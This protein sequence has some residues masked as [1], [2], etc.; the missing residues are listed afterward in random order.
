MPTSGEEPCSPARPWADSRG[1]T[2]SHLTPAPTRTLPGAR[3]DADLLQAADV[4]EQQVLQVAERR[5]VVGGRLRRDAQ[6]ERAARSATA[7][8]DVAGV[9]RERDRG[10]AAGRRAG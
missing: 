5:L 1:A 9:G 6:P 10:R 7:V 2:R 4:D 3:I 8:G